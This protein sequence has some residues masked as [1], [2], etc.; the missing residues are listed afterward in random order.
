MLTV[1]GYDE[2]IFIVTQHICTY[3]LDGLT[4]TSICAAILHFASSCVMM[5]VVNTTRR[6]LVGL[7]VVCMTTSSIV[8]TAV[9]NYFRSLDSIGGSMRVALLN[10]MGLASLAVKQ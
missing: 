7:F 10:R 8:T 4:R 6:R 1:V 5:I 9:S 2:G 3:E